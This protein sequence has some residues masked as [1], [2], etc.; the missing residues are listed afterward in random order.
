MVEYF[1]GLKCMWL[2]RVCGVK[3]G[4]G[5]TNRRDMVW[6]D[7]W[8]AGHVIATVVCMSDCPLSLACCYKSVISRW[9]DHDYFIWTSTRFMRWITTSIWLG[10][11]CM[12]LAPAHVYVSIWLS[13]ITHNLLPDS[14]SEM[15]KWMHTVFLFWHINY[16]STLN[17]E[18]THISKW[19][20]YVIS[21]RDSPVSLLWLFEV[22][23]DEC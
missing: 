1:M 18:R 5:V 11:Y 12:G 7:H 2:A 22:R 21:A 17:T 19:L 4:A 3:T 20:I 8:L 6:Y 15:P 10:E 13:K 16:A 9:L 14:P 23:N